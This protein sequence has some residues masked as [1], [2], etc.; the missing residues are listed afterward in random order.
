[1]KCPGCS[2]KRSTPGPIDGT[3]FCAACGALF[4]TRHIYKGDSYSLV[5][6]FFTSDPTADERAIYFDLETLGSD[7][8]GRR[9]GF[10]DPTTKLLT[11]VG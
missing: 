1:M 10:Y 11:Q 8:L 3:R 2:G 5:M 7:G 4:T 9:H 6:P